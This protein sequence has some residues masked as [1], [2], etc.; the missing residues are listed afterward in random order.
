MTL[1]LEIWDR[2]P[3]LR[4]VVQMNLTYICGKAEPGSVRS[5]LLARAQQVIG[6]TASV[7]QPVAAR[8]TLPA[9]KERPAVPRS[10]VAATAADAL[11][12]TEADRRLLHQVL[13]ETLGIERIY[14]VNLARRPDRYVRVL[15]ELQRYGLPVQRIDAVDAKSAPAARAAHAAFRARSVQ[16]RKPSSRHVPDAVMLEYKTQLSPGVFGYA[17]S[18]AQVLRDA[19]Q[20]GHRR[21]L[22]LDDDVFFSSDAAS[23]LRALAPHLPA[24]LKVLLLGASEYADRTSDAFQR[25]RFGAHEHLY[26]PLPG[27]TCGSFAM[28]YDQSCY[29][30]LLEAVDEADGTFD[31]VALGAIYSRHPDQCMV[32]DPAVCIPDVG[33]SDIRPNA[34]M[35]AQHSEKMGWEFARYPEYT[36]PFHVTVLVNSFDSLRHVGTM[37]SELPSKISLAIHYLSADGLR[38]VIVG[39]RFAPLDSAAKPLDVLD[40]KQLRATAA[41]L[42]VMRSDVVLAWPDHMVVTEESV[43]ASFALALEVAHQTGEPDGIAGGM[44]FSVDAGLPAQPRMHSVVIPCY[45]SVEHVWPSIQSALAQDAEDFEV[46]VVNDNPKHG[47]FSTELMARVQ[48]WVA[49]GGRPDVAQRLRVIGHSINRNASAARNTGL[50]VARGSFISFLD[51]DDLFEPGRLSAIELALEAAGPETG[52]CYCGYSGNWNGTR[53]LARFPQGD[54]GDHVLSLRYG[55]H[56]MCTNTVSYLRETLQRLGG[57]NESYR[58]HQDLELMTRFFEQFEIVAV[59]RFLVQNRPSPVPETF[60]ADVDGLCRLKHQFL[61]DMRREVLRRGKAFAESV[62]DA[63]TKDIVKRDKSMAP[64][65]VAA[66]RTFLESALR[67]A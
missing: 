23:R 28:V 30:E 51:D 31:N 4:P 55:D 14:V 20:H 22:V 45:R 15:R 3:L 24:D 32:V 57:F 59:P 5:S 58:R 26:R 16:D 60:T 65:T 33:D 25:A 11:G 9:T 44:P 19:L 38:P 49:A 34:R 46:I 47:A 56:Y 35:Q 29:Q 27:E 12:R 54:L 18:Q 2:T 21:I 37:R 50:Q 8:A 63:H 6:A 48:A 61:S 52:G 62:V 42:H 17:L 40:G 41:A 64:S 43:L 67:D 36:A 1:Y 53:D 66:I 10:A 39:H 7:R 13:F